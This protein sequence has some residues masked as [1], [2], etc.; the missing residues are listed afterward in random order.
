MWFT[1]FDWEHDKET[2]LENPGLYAIG[3]ENIYFDRITF[4]RWFAYAVVQGTVMFLLTFFTLDG[5]TD[6]L[7]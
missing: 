5:K 6:G 4:W 2:Y 7:F 3:M 1:V